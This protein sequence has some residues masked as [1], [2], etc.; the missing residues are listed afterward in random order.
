M[1]ELPD[2][3][4]FESTSA[5]DSLCQ[6]LLS[7]SVENLQ[8]EQRVLTCLNCLARPVYVCQLMV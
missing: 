6:A 7:S 8:S 3:V 1:L 5:N 2:M 4:T